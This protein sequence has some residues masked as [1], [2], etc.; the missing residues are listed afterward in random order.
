MGVDALSFAF[1]ADLVRREAAIVL[2]PGKEYLVES[3]LLP[4]ARREKYPDLTSFLAAVMKSPEKSPLRYLVV[5]ALTTN[6][7]LFFRDFHPFE[8]LRTTVLPELLPKRAHVRKLNI[9]SAAASTGQEAYTIAMIIREH[10]PEVAGWD[11][12]IMGTDLS[13]TTIAQ[14][15]SGSYSQLEVNRGL[16]AMYLAKYF[17]KCDER[18]LVKD[19]LRRM[20]EFKQMNL[21]MPWPMLPPF[22]LIF[23]RN[24]LIYFDAPTKTNIL[25]RMHNCLLP[26]GLLFLGTAETTINLDA[27]WAP[28]KVG[29]TVAFKQA[30]ADAALDAHRKAA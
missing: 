26:H 28:V 8:A 14:A 13:T 21:A 23:I 29:A 6:E 4:V 16:P 15:R 12:K 2:E 5:D 11:I 9:W 1:V 30:L 27:G 25:G 18:W 3:R 17:T 19:E 22:D 10:F 7:T 24:V 20:C